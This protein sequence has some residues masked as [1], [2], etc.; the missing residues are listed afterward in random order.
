MSGDVRPKA[1]AAQRA[2]RLKQ[3]HQWH[4]I[5]SALCLVAMLLFSVTG[6]TLNHAE[7]IPATPRVTHHELTLPPALRAALASASAPADG[8]GPMPPQLADWLKQ[9]L[10]VSVG[11]REAEWSAAELYLAMPRPGGDAWVRIARDTG[12]VEHEDTDQGVIALL[13]DLHKG[14]HAGAVWHGLLDV[15]ALACLVFTV[16]GLLLLK[17]HAG[18]RRATWP[19]V[20]SG[21]VVPALLALAF[22][23]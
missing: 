22:I 21:L 19:L 14:R 12:A 5:S 3:L 2:R 20:V 13:N 10:G 18:H 4:W 9:S 17:L 16:T 15:L 11:D 1:T 6:L 7:D 23:H 8:R